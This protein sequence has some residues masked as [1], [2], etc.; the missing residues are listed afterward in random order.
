MKNKTVE[1]LK[2][3]SS[4]GDLKAT[5]RLAKYFEEGLSVEQDSEL[6]E[7]YLKKTINIFQKQSLQVKSMN[8]TNF[9]SSLVEFLATPGNLDRNR[10]SNT[11]SLIRPFYLERITCLK[12][13]LSPK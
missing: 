8:L 7:E 13:F 5:F 4:K 11:A 6:Y 3:K 12:E 10:S 9:R 1:K 2:Y